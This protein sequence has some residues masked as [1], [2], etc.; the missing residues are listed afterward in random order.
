MMHKYN[1]YELLYMIEEE[2]D[3]ALEIMINKYSLLIY[4]RIRKFHIQENYID[5]YYQEGLGILI[6][7]IEKYDKNSNMSFTN[8]FDLLLQR[9]IMDLLRKNKKYFESN[10][11]V[12]EVEVVEMYNANIDASFE[13]K[14]VKLYTKLSKFEQ[15][16]FKL[17]YIDNLKVSEIA[18]KLNTTQK[19]IYSAHDRIKSKA[20]M[21]R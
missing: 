5:D 3:E 13:E 17:K 14:I 11:L 15:D 9:R 7:A 6:K 18:L 19:R 10:V 12:E 4:S 8:F 16:V 21:I 1:D 20:L 2:S